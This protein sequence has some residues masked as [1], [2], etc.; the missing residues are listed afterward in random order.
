MPMSGK[1]TMAA[2]SRPVSE[3]K[4]R[5]SSRTFPTSEID[6]PPLQNMARSSSEDRVKNDSATNTSTSPEEI[7]VVDETEYA[8]GMKLFLI[9]ASLLV[10]FF[11]VLLDTVRCAISIH[12]GLALITLRLTLFSCYT[13]TEHYSNSNPQNHR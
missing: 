4:S 12:F 11:T 8:H 13:H 10:T 7:G 6:N 9:L 2:A 5:R 3:D 1:G